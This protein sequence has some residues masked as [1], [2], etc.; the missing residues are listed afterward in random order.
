MNNFIKITTHGTTAQ[1]NAAKGH[2][3]TNHA[4]VNYFLDT[5]SI[6]AGTGDAKEIAKGLVNI[7]LYNTAVDAIVCLEGTEVIGAFL[8]EELRKNGI[9]AMGE[10]TTVNVIS[11]EFNNNSQMIFR[12]NVAPMIR[13]KNV[14]VL[15][16]SMTTG[17]STRKAMESITYY[18]GTLV[19][20]SAI[21][22][23]IDNVDGVP[24]SSI[25]S[26][27]DIPD[28]ISCDFRECPLCKA[29]QKIDALVNHY[30]Y[31]TI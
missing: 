19:G 22:S 18:G 10:N 29:G 3:A 15:T 9:R 6:K 8:G 31:S 17:I 28:Y 27:K 11:P 30:G 26:K 21:F 20:I 2:F 25:F 13:G 5:T 23:I 16:A 12:D 24:V 14:I 7:Y 1:L 4:H